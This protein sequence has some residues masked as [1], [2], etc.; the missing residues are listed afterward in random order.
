[1]GVKIV[2]LLL[3]RLLWVISAI[4]L[5]AACGKKGPP[6]A[7]ILRIPAAID[8]IQA[9][10]SG[11]DV[12]VTLTVPATNIDSSIPVDLGRIEVYGYTGR[13]PPPRARWAELGDLVATFP[14][15]L[16]PP[17][18]P[19]SGAA[20]A[21]SVDGAPLGASPGTMVTVLDTLTPEEL[22][23]GRMEETPPPGR[24][25]APLTPVVTATEPAG[26]R[27]FYVA[28]G[29]S[30]RGRPGPP[31][32]AAEFPLVELPEPPAF[33]RTSYTESAVVVEWPPSGGFLGSLFDHPLGPEDVPLDEALEP[34]VTA[35]PA[36]PTAGAAAPPSSV[37]PVP[38]G[39]VHY[40]VYR[41]VAPDPLAPPDEARPAPWN[42]L[43]PIPINPVPLDAMTFTDPVELD[44]G[45]CYVVRA[46]RGTLPNVIEGD[47]SAPACVTPTDI[48]PP[49]A[50]NRLVAV[51]DE[52]GISLIWEPNGEADLDGYLVLRGEATD[53]TLQPLTPAPIAEPRFRDTHVTAGKKYVYAVVAVDAHLPVP[54]ISAESNRVEETAR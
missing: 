48:F 5:A 4:V 6:L 11:R 29:F 7:P 8:T 41:E 16:P 23:Q 33:V 28:F 27:R 13:V 39:P 42:A 38:A 53:A 10:R 26:L 2:S 15:V 35:P 32:A 12:F 3:R 54:N 1:M 18:A 9:E 37:P 25:R 45:R 31:G 47:A 14:V 24:G 19:A 51:T 50:P 20:P 17:D 34:I 21:E 30:V 40:N 46:I 22:V 49:A 36:V 52:G 44:R 43:R